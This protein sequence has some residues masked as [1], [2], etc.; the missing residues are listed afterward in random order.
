M[1]EF[2]FIN[3]KSGQQR[4]ILNQ[5][6]KLSKSQFPNENFYIFCMFYSHHSWIF[7]IH[8]FQYAK[9]GFH[10]DVSNTASDWLRTPSY[11]LPFENSN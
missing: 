2:M 11:T 10:N 5:K 3:R 1:L 8:N 6:K 9:E 4:I 7:S